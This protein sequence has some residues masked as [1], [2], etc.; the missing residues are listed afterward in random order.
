[1]YTHNIWNRLPLPIYL[2]HSVPTRN[3]ILV[4]HS[5]S[6]GRCWKISLEEQERF[7]LCAGFTCLKTVLSCDWKHVRLRGLDVC[8]AGMWPALSYR[9]Q[10]L[11]LGFESGEHVIVHLVTPL[12]KRTSPVPT[13]DTHHH[14]SFPLPVL[15]PHLPVSEAAWQ[16]C[17]P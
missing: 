10:V 7:L 9:E 11:Q 1:M 12:T 8:P 3:S 14:F 4:R 15:A 6:L 5:Q 16:Y 17:K 2:T 13:D